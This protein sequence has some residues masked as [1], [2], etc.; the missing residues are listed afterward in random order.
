MQTLIDVGLSPETAGAY[1]GQL[2]GGQRQRVGI[3]RA[4][5]AKPK[6]LIADEPVSSLDAPVRRQ[7]LEL[8]G[9]LKEKFG[10]TCI[11]I[12]H[13]LKDVRNLCER[14]AVVENGRIVEC[15]DTEALFL[16]PKH[17]CTKELIGTMCE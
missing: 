2:S 13:D 1:P 3:A 5:A 8:L 10:F 17:P 16:H 6:L 4:L 11:F 15:A 12:S 14:I 7:I 9:E